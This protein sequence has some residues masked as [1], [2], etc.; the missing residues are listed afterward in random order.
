MSTEM[1][2]PPINRAMR[3][4]DRNFFQKDIQISA[5][6]I[7]DLKN[8]WRLRNEFT[9]C[10]DIIML[11]H[12]DPVQPDPLFNVNKKCILLRPQTKHDGTLFTT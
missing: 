11:K 1:F 12:V 3:T 2:R 10:Q 4:L 5:A 6:R 9:K 7:A 8:I